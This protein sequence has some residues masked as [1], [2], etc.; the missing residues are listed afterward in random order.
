MIPPPCRVATVKKTGKR[1]RVWSI[2]VRGGKRTF[3]NTFGEVL[4]V[5]G[6]S[7]KYGPNKK[8][9]AEDVD[10]TDEEL[11]TGLLEGLMRQDVV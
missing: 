6:A 5:S 3:V 9:R 8:F 10:I 7:A 11:S 2:E 1:Y 4:T